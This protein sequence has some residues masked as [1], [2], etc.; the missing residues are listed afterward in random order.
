MSGSFS[1]PQTEPYL[2]IT[3]STKVMEGTAFMITDANE[4]E[5]Y[6][7]PKVVNSWS[8]TGL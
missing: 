2:K 7:I 1:L 4:A 3:A 6:C 5:V 8:I